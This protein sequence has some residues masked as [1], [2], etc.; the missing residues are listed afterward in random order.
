MTAYT[1]YQT[2]KNVS[3]KPGRGKYTDNINFIVAILY[4]VNTYIVLYFILLNTVQQLV[5]LKYEVHMGG[6]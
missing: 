4:D 1:H 2:H 3:S 5:R 6:T